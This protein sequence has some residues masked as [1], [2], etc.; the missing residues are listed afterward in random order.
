[1]KNLVPQQ[2]LLN[3]KVQPRSLG[4]EIFHDESLAEQREWFNAHGLS[5]FNKQMN[6]ERRCAADSVP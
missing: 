1:M 5:P 6:I 3:L 2:R 4:S